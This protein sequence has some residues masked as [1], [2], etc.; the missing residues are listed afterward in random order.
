MPQ[1]TD[2][3]LVEKNLR[4]TVAGLKPATTTVAQS[5]FTGTPTPTSPTV[6]QVQ[7]GTNL[8]ALIH[9]MDDGT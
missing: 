5:Y 3:R 8:A 2:R 9:G 6:A 1:K 4:S 7:S